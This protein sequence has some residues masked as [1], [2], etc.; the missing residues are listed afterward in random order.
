MFAYFRIVERPGYEDHAQAFPGS[1]PYTETVGF[2]TDLSGRPSMDFTTA[3]E[4]AHMWWGGLAYGAKMQGRKILNEGMAQYSLMML[5]KQEDSP[6]LLRQL[7]ASAHEAYLN[8]RKGAAIPELPVIRAE[9]Q[10]PHLTYGKSAHVMFALQE[11]LGADKINLALRRYLERFG[12]KPPPFP[13]SVDLVKEVRA[14]AGPEYQ[15]LITDLFEKIML[16]D[17]QM[18]GVEVAP[19]GG[20]YEVKMDI[21]AHQFEADGL[22]RETEVPLDTWFQLVIFP[23]SKQELLARTPLY[24]AFH[25][26]HAGSQRVTIRVPGKPGAVGVDPFH[27]MYD[28]TPK[29]NTRLLP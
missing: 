2:L 17:V 5:L 16:Y 27:L 12:R 28:R 25:R 22:G 11:L 13:M 1:V 3:H 20:E 26:L 29:N 24:Q 15:S 19:V 7:L 8:G 21:A 9:D 23:D 14:V 18:T 10:Q 6:L 4:L